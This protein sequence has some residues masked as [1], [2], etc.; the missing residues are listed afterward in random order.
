MTSSRLAI[1]S[2]K[3]T[4]ALVLLVVLLPVI[5]KLLGWAMNAIGW[6]LS[7]TGTHPQ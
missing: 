2:L 5:V 1:W 6:W 4:M 7:V 3:A